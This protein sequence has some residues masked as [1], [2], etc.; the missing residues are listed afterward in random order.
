MTD[1]DLRAELTE[2]LTGTWRVKEIF[3]ATIS[4]TVAK[5]L[6][7]SLLPVVRQHLAQAWDDGYDTA[8]GQD[9]TKDNNPHR[10]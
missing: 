3:T 6:A 2:M 5:E 1:E 7:D 10:D 8:C 4:A 9:W